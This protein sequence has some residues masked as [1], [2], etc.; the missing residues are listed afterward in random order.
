[1]FLC[2]PG[3]IVSGCVGTPASTNSIPPT[4]GATKTYEVYVADSGTNDVTVIDESGKV[5][6]TIPVGK[7]PSAIA[8]DASPGF[9]PSHVYIANKGDNTVTVL[10]A[11]DNSVAATIPV[12]N[13]PSAMTYLGHTGS[14]DSIL[15]A[16]SGDGTVSQI[17]IASLKVTATYKTGTNPIAVYATVPYFA[18]LNAGDGTIAVVSN[19]L[20]KV[21]S[22]V[23]VHGAPIGLGSPGLTADFTA[24]SADGVLQPF[25]FNTNTGA[26]DPQAVLNTGA[27]AQH[28]MPLDETHWVLVNSQSGTVAIYSMFYKKLTQTLKAGSEPMMAAAK[29]SDVPDAPLSVY[30]PNKGS[31]SVSWYTG[32]DFESPLAAKTPIA[33]AK[34]AQPVALG[35]YTFWTG[36]AS[37][38]PQPTASSAPTPTPSATPSAAPT[39]TPAADNLYVANYAGGNVAQ[40][41]APFSSTSSPSLTFS[42]T[43]P[44]GGPIGIAANSTYVVTSH[45]TGSVYA[46]RQPVS[47]SSTPAATFGG[48]A[49]GLLTFDPQGNL[50]ATSQNSSVVE[51]VPPF[52]NGTLEAKSLT[53]GFTSSYGI[54]FDASGT[55][56]VSN[57]DS[58]ASIVVYAPPY[59]SPSNIYTI[60]TPNARLHGVAVNGSNLFVAD[61]Y[62]NVVYVYPLPMTTNIAAEVFS[63]T[64]PVGLTFDANGT[65][66]VTAQ[67]TNQIQ[68]FDAPFNSGSRPSATITAGVNGAFGIATG[69]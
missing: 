60:P 51:Y 69:P 4:A 61:T 35:F 19:T 29:A 11:A 58:S 27:P 57:S 39:A 45:V 15:V 41:A 56:Y 18:V 24:A 54:A 28:A 30:V 23:A 17:S 55:M 63:A 5:V 25:A 42:D 40:Y 33:L 37:P 49:F 38:T 1:M 9:V 26:Y 6:K 64:A 46:Y 16:N 14:N 44:V 31:D 65:L 3:L 48:S 13:A 20:H 68:V 8:F 22:L 59:T 32:K 62:N 10:N 53:S 50:W 67:G 36:G 2:A 52:T 47:A 7:S 66:Y 12:G 34:G 21:Q 43:T